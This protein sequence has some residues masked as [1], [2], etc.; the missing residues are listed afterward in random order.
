M[1]L[2][3]FN[4]TIIAQMIVL[5]NPNLQLELHNITI[6]IVIVIL[7]LDV[8]LNL[9]SYIVN[10]SNSTYLLNIFMYLK[11]IKI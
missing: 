11:N 2:F 5:L 7:L 6:F 4:I 9:I 8:V 10:C 3:I 1:L